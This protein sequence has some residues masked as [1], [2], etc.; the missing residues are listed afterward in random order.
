MVVVPIVVSF[1]VA[2]F[3]SP[4]LWHRAGW[5]GALL[6][7]AQVAVVGSTAA[8]LSQRATGKFL[9]L[10]SLLNMTLV[11]PDRAPSRFG[12]AL[13]SGT[14][15]NLNDSLA[16]G[17]SRDHQEAAEQL[18]RMV[19]AL[20][21]HEPLTRGHTE[22][23]RA[24]TDLIAQE[25]NL[26]K[27]DREKLQWAAMVH[28]IGKLTVPPEILNSPRR[29]TDD[30]WEILCQHPI[31]GGELV[32][33]LAPWLGQWRFAAS[34]HHERWD[35]Q[36]YP[37]GLAG[38]DIAMAGRIVAVAD[39]YEVIT[40]TRSY[41]KALSS[42]A[43]R[44]EMVACSGEQFDPDV[45]RALLN[46]S[47]GRTG[48]RFG[49][50]GWFI[51][52]GGLSALPRGVGQA[53]A[54]TATAAAIATGV[55]TATPLLAAPIDSPVETAETPITT[56]D[57]APGQTP[58]AV[59]YRNP[60]PTDEAAGQPQTAATSPTT[61]T[62]KAEPDNDDQAQP[63]SSTDTPVTSPQETTA[64][65]R[66]TITT[67]QATTTT[68]QATATTTAG[69]WALDDTDTGTAG[70]NINVWVLANDAPPAGF[71][72]PTLEIVGPPSNGTA[73]VQ[74]PGGGA[75]S[76]ITYR[77]NAEFTGIDQ[78]T[79]QICDTVGYC[80]TATATLTITS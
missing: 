67:A 5:S 55:V 28:D 6:F 2:R 73:S 33:P 11:F 63:S 77:S 15:K 22:R 61:S 37:R 60:D 50:L 66:P 76:R 1:A 29:L 44:Q 13:R 26:P 70:S 40:S 38:T 9:P 57:L 34:Q 64:T 35:G 51:E 21:A 72:Y 68:T 32:E 10:A 47:L 14:F 18:V 80:S 24:F 42:E 41:K 56:Q 78:F 52:L 12:V 49:F 48:T 30:E 58:V 79:Y 23:V 65:T 20:G 62:K 71:D 46:A 54:A 17:S 16:G 4:A 53:I 8:L 69:S 25:L 31:A 27:A 7:I 75:S 74:I 19:G 45:V 43:A 59:P 39:A 3:V 36:G